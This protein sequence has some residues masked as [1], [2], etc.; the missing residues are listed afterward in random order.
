MVERCDGLARHP[1]T[2]TGTA[3]GISPISTAACALH[4]HAEVR[5]GHD[6]SKAVS[7]SARTLQHGASGCLTIA[8]VAVSPRWQKSATDHMMSCMTA[9][10]KACQHVTH[11][12]RIAPLSE[13][14]HSSV[15]CMRNWHRPLVACLPLAPQP[16]ACCC[17][18]CASGVLCNLDLQ[19]M[20][21][22][23]CVLLASLYCWKTNTALKTI[24]QLASTSQ[25][26]QQLQLP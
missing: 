15:D 21:A 4:Q 14:V 3:S 8:A 1:I 22:G 12:T 5:H 20:A 24:A 19:L 18:V 2:A 26:L 7:I 13:L 16:L 23:P 25:G 11:A 9:E 10:Q 6:T 17:Q